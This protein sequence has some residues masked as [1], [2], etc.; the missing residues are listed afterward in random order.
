[1]MVVAYPAL[2][3][4]VKNNCLQHP[5]YEEDVRWLLRIGARLGTVFVHSFCEA[6]ARAIPSPFLLYSLAI[7][8]KEVKICFCFVFYD[9]HLLQH[10]SFFV[11]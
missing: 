5:A 3:Y 1:M 8:T 6:A 4:T 10:V 7:E 2:F 11:F 9:H